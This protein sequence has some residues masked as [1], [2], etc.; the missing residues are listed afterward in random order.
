MFLKEFR[1]LTDH[2]PEDMEVHIIGPSGECQEAA[3]ISKD[4]LVEDDPAMESY[5][6]HG[7]VLDIAAD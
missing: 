5:P 3:F 6:D 1:Q 7:I 2:L 4:D